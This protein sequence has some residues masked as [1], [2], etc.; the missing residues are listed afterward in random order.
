MIITKMSLP[1]RTFLRGVGAAVALPLLDAMVPAL[2]RAATAAT[3]VRRL[4]VVYVPNGMSMGEWTPAATGAGFELTSIL[5]PLAPFRDRLLVL[6]GLDAP[7][8]PGAHTRASTAFLTGLPPR[9][10]PGGGALAGTSIDQIVAEHFGAETQLP[11]LEVSLDARDE[12]GVCDGNPC[13]MTNTIAWRTASMPLPGEN[14]PRAVFERLFGDVGSTDPAVRRARTKASRS[15]LDSVTAAAAD[16]QRQLGPADR[17][18]LGEYLDGVRAIEARIQKAEAQNAAGVPVLSQPAGIPASYEEHAKLMFDLQVLAYQSDLTR[19]ITF[20]IGR[21]Y[22][23]RT[24]PQVGVAEAHHALS[25]HQG[26]PAK[27][28]ALAR[29]NAYHMSLFAYYLDKLRATPDGD[30]TLLDHVLLVYGAGMSDSN[31]HEP[32]N[33]PVL[34]AGGAGQIKGGRHLQY[35]GDSLA[36]LLV[37][38]VDKLG[39]PVDHV[40]VSKGE[41]NI[42]T[43]S[44]V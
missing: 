37:T 14:N 6:S 40:G 19:V 29:V 3:P 25:H 7:P 32:K 42:D 36:N 13:V 26:D 43:L 18:R 5:A 33:I 2:S 31:A 38:V 24:Y 8:G 17:S 16:L 41:L 20:M 9:T 12:V 15:I 1:R 35:A 22:S 11:S 28:A 4:G 10:G 44:D 30:G 39:V 21:E 27:L 34:L 23:G